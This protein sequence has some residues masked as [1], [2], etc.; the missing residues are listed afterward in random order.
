MDKFKVYLRALEPDDYKTTIKWRNDDEIWSMV[1]GP[2]YFVSSE[3][4]R[5][6]V[7]N[8]INNKDEIRLGICL[9]IDAMLIG[10][11]SIIDI[12]WIN[13][14][15]GC[16]AMIGE[17]K[18]WGQGLATEA[19]LLVLKYAFHER[20]F[21]SIRGHV[22]ES[23]VASLRVLEKCGYKKEGTLRNAVFK[24]GRFHDLIVMS[25]LREEFELIA[26]NFNCDRLK[27]DKT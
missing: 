6:W 22:L 13:R 17:K 11:I 18:Y 3:Y 26:S 1:V 15:A 7:L 27:G 24:G 5:Q 20:G 10:L 8:A 2:K 4:E 19:R 14:S 25:I 21:E 16:P 23:N 9:K 12:D